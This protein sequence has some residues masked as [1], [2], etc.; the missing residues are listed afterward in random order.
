MAAVLARR[1]IA[2]REAA[3]E[4]LAADEWF[5]PE[6]FDGM[7]EVV[8]LVLGA[9]ADGRRITVYGDFDCDGVCATSVL[10]SAL[11]DLGADCDWFIP[12]RISDGYGLNP[13]ALRRLAERGTSL[14]ITVDCG[15][16]AVAEVALARE[17]GLGIVVTDHHQT[18]P[19]LP[20][21][22]I[23]HPEISRYPFPHLCG[24][25]V[26][27]KLAAAL[28]K[29]SGA[30]AERDEAD[31][32][33][34]ALATVADM[35]P[36]TGENRH[37]V[38]EGVKVAARARRVGLAALMADAKVDP[39]SV[40]AEDFGFRLGPRINAAGRLYRADAGVELFLAD[41]RERAAEIARELSGVNAER[42]MVEREVEQMARAVLREMGDPGPAVVVAG[43]GWHPGVLG[44]VASKLVKSTGRPSVVISL[45]DGLGRGSAR[46]VPGLDLHAALEDCREQLEG[47]GG[48]AGAAGL[49]VREDMLGAFREAL[50]EA[51]SNRVGP[52]PAERFTEF[53]AVAGGADL[54]MELAED[55]ERLAPFGN[56]NPAVSL[57]IPGARIEDLQEMGEGKHCR[58]TVRS[59][60]HRARG[61]SFG[62]TSFGL[63]EDQRAD[64]VAE[65]CL[66]HWNG[67]VEP[68]LRVIEAARVPEPRPLAECEASE[69]WD[70]FEEAM[71]A[72]L[73][74]RD[75]AT[76]PG[77][78][79]ASSRKGLPGVLMAEMISSGE[80]LVILSADARQRWMALSGEGMARFLPDLP[81]RD[82]GAVQVQGLWEGSPRADIECAAGAQVL[83][84]DFAAIEA[85]EGDAHLGWAGRFDRLILLDPPF[86]AESI[87]RIAGSGLPVHLLGG[88]DEFAF[89]ARVARH[90]LD[91]TGQL[92]ELYRDLRAQGAVDGGELGGEALRDLLSRDGRSLRSPEH[93]AVLMRVLIEADLARSSGVGGARVAGVVSSEGANLSVSAVFA[94]HSRLH[95]EHQRFLNQFETQTQNQ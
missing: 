55:I 77:V 93:A 34:V 78:V 17:L 6:E 74:S 48:H 80:R 44:I 32:D 37:L 10:V 65:L 15:V 35:M 31:L 2:S 9:I 85:L 90:R 89:S 21:C 92:R 46:S 63:G 67:S 22:P 1:G 49:T 51:V 13:D 7:P 70:R 18:G 40:T 66:N 30:A 36:L 5:A 81:D 62:R 11:R 79:L 84:T 8:N 87:T 69:W 73:P 58:F 29:A 61:V 72:Q 86:T 76:G 50:D 71:E 20:D 64:L 68:Q 47:F 41:S 12:G 42:R 26:A 16:T 43:E 3:Q 23:L 59:G 28:R 25:G 91:L 33:L 14:V 4:F 19:E 60:S 75:P 45:E 27:A 94:H 88:A 24:T 53:H 82:P 54:G 57:L 83:L 95:E 52:E 56:A 38:R 39:A